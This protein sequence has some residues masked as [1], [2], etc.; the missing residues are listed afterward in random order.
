MQV[1]KWMVLLTVTFFVGLVGTVMFFLGRD[2]V[3]KPNPPTFAENAAESTVANSDEVRSAATK[4]AGIW[5]FADGGCGTG[6]GAAYT[7]GGRFVEGDAQTGIEGRWRVENGQLVR[8]NEQEFAAT[9]WDE[10]P[11]VKAMR[12]IDRFPIIELTATKLVFKDDRG[13][14]FSYVRCREGQLSF[15]DG[16]VAKAS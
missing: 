2:S 3:S 4:I 14:Q 5:A 9:D 16:E 15:V 10:P 13:E 7:I 12:T 1:P 8:T 6:Y 11:A